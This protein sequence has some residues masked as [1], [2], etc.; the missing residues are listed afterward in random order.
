MNKEIQK[1]LLEAKCQNEETQL[2]NQCLQEKIQKLQGKLQKAI[3]YLELYKNKDK[4]PKEP[5]YV[6]VD[7]AGAVTAPTVT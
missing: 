4:K 7:R 5:E 1:K 2:V 6:V 3:Q